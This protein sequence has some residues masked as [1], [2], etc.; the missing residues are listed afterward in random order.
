MIIIEGPDG[1]G[2]T[3]LAKQLSYDLKLEYHHMGAPPKTKAEAERRAFVSISRCTDPCIQDRSTLISECVYGAA[4]RKEGAWLDWRKA[5]QIIHLVQPVIIYCCPD[6]DHL[7]PVKAPYDSDEYSDLVDQN[8]GQIIAL[9]DK[10][11]SLLD[12][13][14]SNYN[15]SNNNGLH[16]Y[17]TILQ[18]CKMKTALCD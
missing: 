11:F 9:Y 7:Q 4:L 5:R 18:I 17:Q 3:V 15:F 10:F 13:V 6:L 16:Q 1:A 2:K 8:Q 12:V 14:K